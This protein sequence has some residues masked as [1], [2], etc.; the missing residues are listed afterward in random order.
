MA[1]DLKALTAEQFIL[2]M[3]K[4]AECHSFGHMGHTKWV[5]YVRPHFD[6]RDGKCFVIKLDEKVFTSKGSKNGMYD[7]ILSYLDG[8]STKIQ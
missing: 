6:M 1:E 7:D 4:I 5:K 3:S 2:I 8:V